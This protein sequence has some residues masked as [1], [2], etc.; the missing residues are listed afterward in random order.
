MHRLLRNCVPSWFDTAHLLL[1]KPGLLNLLKQPFLLQQETG[2]L[3]RLPPVYISVL[4]AWLI[5]EIVQDT[6]ETAGMWVIEEGLFFKKT[7][8]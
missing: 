1:R 5:F 6:N 8:E 7:L 4:Q 2:A 3:T